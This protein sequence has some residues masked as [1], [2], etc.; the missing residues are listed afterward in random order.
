MTNKKIDELEQENKRLKQKL[1]RKMNNEAIGSMNNLLPMLLQSAIN[2][3][4]SDGAILILSNQNEEVDIITKG[5]LPRKTKENI[6]NDKLIEKILKINSAKSYNIKEE[7]FQNWQEINKYMNSIIF[8]PLKLQKDNLRGTLIILK[9]NK[10]LHLFNNAIDFSMLH[11][12]TEQIKILIQNKKLYMQY[13]NKNDLNT[14]Y[15]QTIYSLNKA[16]SAKDEYTS[17]HSQRVAKFSIHIARALSMSNHEI[18]KIK[19]GAMLHDIGKINIPE[20]I[21]RKKGSLTDKEYR[22]IQSHPKKG[23]EILN[24]D[25]LSDDLSDII[26]YHHERVD[27]EGYPKK[28]KGKNIPLFAKIVCI[29]DAWDAM[30]SDRTY[31]KALGLDIAT[32]ELL[33]NSGTQ[34]DKNIIK[35]L[36]K[37][38]FE[39]IKKV[40]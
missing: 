34:F 2:L 38:D 4:F 35:E 40:V 13:D 33:E 6:N 31:R 36:K 16:I 20:S 30:T 37:Q 11:I 3:T 19:D 39:I 26:H 23:I 1:N 9:N 17:G 22:V 14:I 18:S 7:E 29:A 10:N 32:N 27:G 24:I 5:N 21:L 28:I 12:L 15:L 25:F 8:Y